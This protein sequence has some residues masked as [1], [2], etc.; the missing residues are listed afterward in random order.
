MSDTKITIDHLKELQQA[1]QTQ[2]V[3]KYIEKIDAIHGIN[4][5]TKLK[6]STPIIELG[7]LSKLIRSH[8]TK[9]GI[10]L[11]P[12]NLKES[13]FDAI[14]KELKNLI[15]NIFYLFSLLPLFYKDEKNNYTDFF[16]EKLDEAVLT[17]INSLS[18]LSVELKS[19]FDDLSYD[20]HRLRCIGLIWSNCDS[21]DL[22]V[23]LDNF[24]LLAD[25]LK[26]SVDTIKDIIEEVESFLDDPEGHVQDNFE[27]M[28]EADFFD[29]NSDNENPD[30]E[31][32]DPND[33][34]EVVEAVLPF[35]EKWQKKLVLLK[36]F[37]NSIRNVMNAKDKP[38]IFTINNLNEF[39]SLQKKALVECDD[40][41][42]TLQL[43]TAEYDQKIFD[44][45]LS[46]LNSCVDDMIKIVKT[47]KKSPNDKNEYL[48]VWKRKFCEN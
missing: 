37:Y 41:T 35:M 22:L 29:D 2:F 10:V 39:Y 4:S 42:S 26:D 31:D 19:K 38:K 1:I 18:L 25:F 48:N 21:F 5:K 24:T 17:M 15:D 28:S 34:K 11:K 9:I 33:I 30:G 8:V 43:A 45:E 16:L 3:D 7:K 32:I 47:I 46:G 27:F 36:T 14:Y 12:E 13:N 40:I 23:K 6:D 20:E 44:S